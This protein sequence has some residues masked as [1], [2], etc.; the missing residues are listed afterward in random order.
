M[1]RYIFILLFL[2]FSLILEAQSTDIKNSLKNF[3]YQQA[4]LLISKEKKTAE[5]DFLAAKCYKNIAQ[6]KK[7]IDLLK[8]IV[9]QNDSNIAAIIE[10]AD[11][12]QLSGNFNKSK[13]YYF[14]AL[15]SS[16]N[17]RYIQLSYLNIAFKLRD[18][19]TIIHLANKMLQQD[20]LPSLYP[21]LGDCFTQLSMKDSA[22]FYYK[23]EMD[24]YPED[25]NTLAKLS[26]L[27]L[28]DGHYTKL[29]NTTNR[30]MQADFSNQQINQFN[31]MGH[32]MNKDYTRSIYRLRSLFQQG[33]SSFLTNYYL[34]AS[35]YATEDYIQAF[36]HL[37]QAYKKDSSNLD[38][39]FFLGKSAIMSGHQL[40]GIR[41]L[42]KGI[43]L[44]TPKD[45]V[46]F[47]Y[48]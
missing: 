44:M 47:N 13:F 30:Y 23:K 6:Y 38:L 8:E 18:W 1:I 19:K 15:Q 26:K 20:T 46:L 39:I 42:K 9:R 4:I 24:Y 17:N 34:G 41:I 21:V 10:L 33:D 3:D 37:K 36:D 27:Y 5:M 14:M 40:S 32:C 7:T 16:P 25:Y 28:V 12:Y 45:S 43:E 11:C 2:C 35:Y 22:I 31:G 29:I 48:Y